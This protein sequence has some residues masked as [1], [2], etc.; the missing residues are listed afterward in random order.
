MSLDEERAP[1]TW[2][3]TEDRHCHVCGCVLRRT[4]MT[5]QEYREQTHCAAHIQMRADTFPPISEDG[6]YPIH[7]VSCPKCG[8][9]TI[10]TKIN[11]EGRALCHICAAEANR[12]KCPICQ[13]VHTPDECDICDEVD[14]LCRRCHCE[15]KHPGFLEHADRL[16]EEGKRHSIQKLKEH[17]RVPNQ[18]IF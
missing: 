7:Q 2:Q 10:K 12:V 16:L 14:M 4:G 3:N 9:E 1:A 5:A 6:I 18:R 15:V 13:R 8:N 11:G 17:Y